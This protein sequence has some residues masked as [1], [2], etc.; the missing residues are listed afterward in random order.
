MNKPVDILIEARDP[1]VIR[2]GR[3]FGVDS[4]LRMKGLPWPYPSTTAGALRTLAGKLLGGEFTPEVI[5]KLLASDVR[6]PLPAVVSERG[7]WE[8]RFPRP[9]DLVSDKQ[10]SQ[11]SLRPTSTGAFVANYPD[12]WLSPISMVNG[13]DDDFKPVDLPLWWTLRQTETWL[14]DEP[15]KIAF[16]K[17]QNKE[18]PEPDVRVHV[19]INPETG[20]AEDER[21][22]QTTGLSI[23]HDWRI[24]IRADGGLIPTTDRQMS[25]LGGERRFAIWE[26]GAT[27][28]GWTCPAT[29]ASAV[30]GSRTV[31]MVLATPALF[32]G[33]WKPGWLDDAGRGVIPGSGCAVQLVSAVVDRWQAVSGY[34]YDSRH[35]SQR[36]KPIKRLAPAGSVYFFRLLDN[37]EALQAERV[38]LTPVSD[39]DDGQAGRDG[40][41][42]AIWGIWREGKK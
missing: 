16:G 5:A 11:Y 35:G 17:S 18:R 27:V 42:L 26:V 14:H 10:G 8:L 30:R 31:R 23:P 29:I 2:D 1:V 37:S 20:A 24:A 12:A 22:F 15:G 28:A 41:G 36:E 38:W 6:G 39:G 9:M 7:D 3:P 13:P 21:L 40:F 25:P 33:G 4:G 32:Q 19:Q 34:S